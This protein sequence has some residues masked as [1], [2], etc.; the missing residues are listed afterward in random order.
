MLNRWIKYDLI[1]PF[2]MP[3]LSTI[4]TTYNEIFYDVFIEL[5]IT[6]EQKQKKKK[7]FA[8]YTIK[9][10]KYVVDA[11]PDLLKDILNKPWNYPNAIV[12]YNGHTVDFLMASPL[13]RK[14]IIQKLE[15]TNY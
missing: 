9:D 7:P 8:E 5:D 11:T 4:R 12:H 1:R 2:F 13:E 14:E 6:Q 10:K 3:T 15:S